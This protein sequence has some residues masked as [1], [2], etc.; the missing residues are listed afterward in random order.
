MPLCLWRASSWRASATRA[1]SCT[2]TTGEVMISR[3]RTGG[4][5]AAGSSAMIRSKAARAPSVVRAK[6]ARA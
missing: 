3:A 4:T 2:V 6:A 5:T 1:P